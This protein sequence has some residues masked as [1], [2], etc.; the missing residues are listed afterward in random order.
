VEN[1]KVSIKGGQRGVLA[2]PQSCGQKAT[3]SEFT[4]WTAAHGGGGPVRSLSDSFTVGGDCSSGFSPRLAAGMSTQKARGSGTFSFQF[5]REDGEQWVNGLTAE[6]PAGLL[7]SVRDVQLCTAGQ[8]VAGSC[9]AGSR[10]G[11]VDA[12]AGSGSP[13][14][15]EKKG[16]AF[17]TEGYKGCP[18]GLAVVVPVI[19]GPFD[20]SSP[21]TDLGSIVVRQSVCVDRTDAHV[22]ATSDPLPTIWHGV[23]LRVRS[24]TVNVDRE[25]FMLNPSSCDAKAVEASFVAPSGKGA[26]AAFP[27]QAA[28]CA[29]LP[30]KPRLSLRLTGRKQVTTGKHPGVRAVVRQTG[31]SEAGIERAEVRLPKTLALDVN[32]AQALCEFEDGTKADPENRCP[33]GSIVGRARAVSPLLNDP[34]VGNVY[35]VKNVRRSS[36]G[37]LIRT[38][39]MLVVAL[40]GEI[41]VNLRGESDVKRGR[42]VN[43]FDEVPDAPISQFN[44]NIKGGR[45]GILAVTR[46][47]RSRINLCARGRQVAAAYIDGHNGRRHDLNIGMRKPCPSRKRSK[48]SCK[49]SKQKATKACKR[50]AKRKA[51][52]RRR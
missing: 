8:A 3:A 21:Q 30:F 31:V 13:F 35:F 51:A 48:A 25:K 33:K 17:L 12:S 2:M 52:A 7:A 10:I 46:T 23:P 27:F 9:P 32:N 1:I 45:N 34:L 24:V 42:L 39:P 5:T 14:V 11:T 38:L 40:R 28:G 50:V 41:A 47:S 22:T 16:Q 4:P 6:L 26:L 43:V 20:G 29:N 49:T 18:Y 19:A 44:M 15:L 37:N 36:T